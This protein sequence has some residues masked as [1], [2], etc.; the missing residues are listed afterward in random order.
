[1]T[2][3][4]ANLKRHST[5]PA[6]YTNTRRVLGRYQSDWNEPYVL[7]VLPLNISLKNHNLLLTMSNFF[8]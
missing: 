4:A 8:I 6:L 2:A 1:M 7:Y 5:Y 3:C